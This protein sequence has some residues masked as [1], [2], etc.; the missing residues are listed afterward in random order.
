MEIW[1]HYAFS[2]SYNNCQSRFTRHSWHTSPDWNI[3]ILSCISSNNIIQSGSICN[4]DRLLFLFAPCDVSY[5]GFISGFEFI[6]WHWFNSIFFAV[7][8][9]LLPF[10]RFG[11][12]GDGGKKS[13]AGQDGL[14]SFIECVVVALDYINLRWKLDKKIVCGTWHTVHSFVRWWSIEVNGGR[15]SSLFWWFCMNLEFNIYWRWNKYLI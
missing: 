9:F 7:S 8:C 2:K 11:Y 5:V 6:A 15:K 13:N 1:K 4:D 14:W 12:A 3:L 10:K